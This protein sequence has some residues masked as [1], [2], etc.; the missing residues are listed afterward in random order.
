MREAAAAGAA[1]AAEGSSRMGA[2]DNVRWARAKGFLFE[3]DEAEVGTPGCSG[4]PVFGC[5]LGARLKV[6]EKGLAGLGF[7][8][9]TVIVEPAADEIS[10][11]AVDSTG[12]TD[13]VLL[14]VVAAKLEVTVG[15]AVEAALGASDPA[16]ATN[17]A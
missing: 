17:V 7:S 3:T 15:A 13:D 11:V 8:V 16:S 2:M 14:D 12:V 5:T 6:R 1:E 4:V 9:A 10:E